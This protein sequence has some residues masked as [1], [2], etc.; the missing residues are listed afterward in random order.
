MSSD[1]TDRW[2]LPMLFA[3]QAQ[4]EIFHNEALIRIDMLLHG[5]AES[6][7][8]ASP[9][10]M[11]PAGSCWIVAADAGGA[12]AGRGGLLACWTEGGWRFIAPQAGL[13]LMV[14]DRGHVVEYDGAIWRDGPV[15]GDRL[16]L[17][18]VQI[19]GPRQPGIADVAGGVV[20]DAEAR[21][22]IGAI[23]AALRGHGLIAM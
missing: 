13:R 21:A 8:L 17:N 9:P 7:D 2:Q 19:I 5:R 20:A 4:K 6:A 10:D 15:R 16:F 3:G 22:A 18:D 23:L 11:P 14:A 12:W 1:A